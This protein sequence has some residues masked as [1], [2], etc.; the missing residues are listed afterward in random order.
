MGEIVEI[1][2]DGEGKK[3]ITAEDAQLDSY[4]KIHQRVHA[5][6]EEI[7]K[8]YTNNIL[9]EFSD[10][11]ELHEKTIQSI[12]SLCPI[13]NSIVI[14]V[15]VFHNEGEAAKFNSFEDFKRHNITS[16][17]PTAQ[18]SLDYKFV[19]LDNETGEFENYRVIAQVRSRVAE[20]KQIENE[21]P[22]FL[23]KAL[24]TSLVTQTAKITILYGD[25]VKARH[26]TAMFDEW[27]KGCDE[28]KSLKYISTVK[29]WSHLL[30]I[31]GK[32][33]IYILLAF[34]MT[35]SF[36]NDSIEVTNLFLMQFLILYSVVFLMVGM[37]SG[38]F[39]SRIEMSIDSYLSLSYLK[40]NK[41]D[42]KAIKE[43]SDRNKSSA[44]WAIAGIV[45]TVLIGL[46]T[47]AA[48][49]IIKNYL[50]S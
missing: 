23:S 18:I 20:L 29:K 48:Y 26:F 31:F 49:D 34:F 33:I 4:F 46:S 12:K 45:G 17:N 21:A 25:Y 8:S 47:N 37:L 7:S 28:S 40:I 5:K 3:I 6:S 19:I 16:P 27:I 39:L 22:P 42:N 9:V 30:S 38:L 11:E 35:S 10:I 32:I 43:Y 41:G 36:R 44:A 50:F 15:A 1:L 14:R 13:R 2:E 24:I